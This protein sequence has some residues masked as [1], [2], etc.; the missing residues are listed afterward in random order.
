MHRYTKWTLLREILVWIYTIAVL[1]PFY[2]LINVALKDKMQTYNTDGATPAQNPSLASFAEVINNPSI[3]PKLFLGLVNSFTITIV[4][5]IG[6]VIFGS[7]TSYIL[8]RRTNRL[9]KL[10]FYAVLGG[11]VVPL[12]LGTVPL[13]IGAKNLGLL[14]NT[15]GM[16]VIYMAMFMPLA[17]LLYSGF[18]RSLPVEYEEAA[19][20]DGA[21]RFRTYTRIVFPLVAPA[22]GTV[23]IMCGVIIFNDFFTPLI[24][25]A[26]SDA[27]TIGVVVYHYVQSYSAPWNDVFAV[28]I[29]AVLPMVVMY[30]IFQKRFIQ[31]FAG[32]IKS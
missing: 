30:A 2:L 8:V 16:G 5:V 6:L 3:G 26:G 31:G 12:Q 13:Y 20:I 10:A 17:V 27:P 23:A 25:L 28:L 4:A 18:F 22:T 7:V 24:F 1:S 32:G 9:S 19:F 14:G 29:L 21:S 15:P 11:I